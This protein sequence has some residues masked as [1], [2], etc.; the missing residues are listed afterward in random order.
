MRK[1]LSVGVVAVAMC[2]SSF[3]GV[4]KLSYKASKVAVKES[5]KAS[6]KVV[7]DSAK[8]SRN[9]YKVAKAILY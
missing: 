7:K 9:S 8:V 4:S 6:A 2:L 3:A 5:A 1:V